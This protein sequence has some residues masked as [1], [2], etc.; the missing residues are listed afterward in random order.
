MGNQVRILVADAGEEFRSL[1]AETLSDEEDLDIVGQ[2]GDGAELVRMAGELRPDVLVMDV[3]LA[4]MDGLEALKRL[5]LPTVG[6]RWKC[7]SCLIL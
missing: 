6:R 3:L 2:T 5:T 1:L 4:Q 7:W